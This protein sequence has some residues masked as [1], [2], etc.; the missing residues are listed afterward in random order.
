MWNVCRQEDMADA[1]HV[2]F[3]EGVPLNVYDGTVV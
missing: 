1:L 2:F 3:E